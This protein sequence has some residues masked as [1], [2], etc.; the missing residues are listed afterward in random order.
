LYYINWHSDERH[1]SKH[2]GGG[3]GRPR[4]QRQSVGIKTIRVVLSGRVIGEGVA[5]A[6][7]AGQAD[8][9]NRFAALQST[10][11]EGVEDTDTAIT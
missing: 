8:T 1:S 6:Q 3:S 2:S 5:H 4:I 11:M 9:S 10:Q 7:T